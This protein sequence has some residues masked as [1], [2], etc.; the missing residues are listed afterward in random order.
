MNIKGW[1]IHTVTMAPRTGEVNAK[2]DPTFG[3]KVTLKAR[4]ERVRRRVRS[5]EGVEVYTE[6]VMATDL[7]TVTDGDVFWLPA[8]AGLPAD[9]VTSFAAGRTPLSIDRATTK[10]GQAPFVV[11]YF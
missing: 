10:R 6:T 4:V 1:L 11:V 8:I 5:S 9:D 2:G 3:A 7:M